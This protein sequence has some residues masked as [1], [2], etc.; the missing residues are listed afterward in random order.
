[1]RR[2]KL[3]ARVSGTFRFQSARLHTDSVTAV[4]RRFLGKG[5]QPSQ[6]AHQPFKFARV[7]YLPWSPPESH[8]SPNRTLT[9]ASSRQ[10][11]QKSASICICTTRVSKSKHMRRFEIQHMRAF[12]RHRATLSYKPKQSLLLVPARRV[13][14]APFRLRVHDLE[15]E[16]PRTLS[17]RTLSAR[18]CPADTV[19]TLSERVWTRTGTHSFSERARQH[20]HRIAR[21]ALSRGTALRE[22]LHLREI[23]R[24]S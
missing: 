21:C 17:A 14:T 4:S 2:E 19:R 5:R 10:D 11:E 22:A 12:D 18:I 20:V 9:S 6:S 8:P 15:V 23:E 13:R 1:M 7:L 3:L 24:S 16:S